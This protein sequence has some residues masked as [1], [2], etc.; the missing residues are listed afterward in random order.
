M[1]EGDILYVRGQFAVSDDNGVIERFDIEISIDLRF[2]DEVPTVRAVDKRIPATP[3][4][5]INTDGTACVGVPE[6]W[7]VIRPDASFAT[8]MAGPV[9]SFFIGQ[10]LVLRG[11]PWP[12]GERA[13]GTAGAVEAFG[14][15]VGFTKLPELR[16]A[17]RMLKRSFVAGHLNCPCGS[18]KKLRNCHLEIVRSAQKRISP[19]I[20]ERMLERLGAC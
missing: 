5:H 13:H 7:L 19:Q 1:V 10:A 4:Y 16:E 6:E 9:R 20:A 12:I 8:F 3:D 11:E 14:E 18:G 15:L 2:P 17:L